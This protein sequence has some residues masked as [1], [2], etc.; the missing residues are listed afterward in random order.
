[1]WQITQVARLRPRLAS[2]YRPLLIR[3]CLIALCA[4]ITFLSIVVANQTARPE[5]GRDPRV[6]IA[7]A[8]LLLLVA[9]LGTV[10]LP[11]TVPAWLQPLT[12][13]LAAALV[14]GALRRTGAL[15]LPYILVPLTTAAL[16]AGLA[17]GLVAAA[18]R[19]GRAAADRPHHRARITG[20]RRRQGRR[21]A[22]DVD[23]HLRRRVRRRG[24][25]QAGR[26]RTPSRPRTRRTPT[27]T[28]CCPSCT[29][30]RAS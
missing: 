26:V 23:A 19:V 21:R 16:V 3:A 13:T 9:A 30:W 6:A 15:F 18:L 29:S 12:E 7:P 2:A 22:L 24:V 27:P 25:D 11:R 20:L 4:L 14:V 1:M 28:G 5:E 10:P 8:L 17:G